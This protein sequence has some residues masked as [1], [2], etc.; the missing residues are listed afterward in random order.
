MLTKFYL[1]CVL[2]IFTKFSDVQS[3]ECS[4]QLSTLG[5]Y[6]CSINEQIILSEENLLPV[7]GDHLPG[8]DN[9][10]VTILWSVGSDIQVFPSIVIDEFIN[11]ESVILSSGTRNFKSHI[12]NC[13]NLGILLL[14][15]NRITAISGGIFRNCR[16][17]E[18]LGMINGLINS[19]DE[20]AFEGLTGLK[21][22]TL[23][24]NQIKSLAP[25]TFA[26]LH[27]LTQ[28]SIDN[29]QLE[30]ITSGIFDSL[31]LLETL[32]L[33]QNNITSWDPSILENNLKLRT[34]FLSGNL[35]QIIDGNTFA[36]LQNLRLLSVGSL[37]E[38]IPTFLNLGQL[39]EL[40]LN[41]NRIKEVSA[42]SFKSLV[43]LKVLRLSFNEIELVN[44]TM[45]PEKILSQL[46]NLT[47]MFNRLTTLQ[48]NA[49]SMLE[50]MNMLQ[51]AFNQIE[52]LNE[53]TIRPITQ[54]RYLDIRSNRVRK[55]EQK[56]F[57]GVSIL[58][59]RA[60]NNICFNANFTIN[61][62]LNN[63]DFETRI[64]PLMENCFNF[65]TTTKDNLLAVIISFFIASI[66]SFR[67]K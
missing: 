18:T 3:V 63:Y 48:D 29:N 36:N 4:F 61:N 66:M 60:N 58:E 56:L 31:T 50:N 28:L 55:I 27:L 16:R 12:S 1:I 11:L 57:D 5:V 8:Y 34:L 26:N 45:R 20:N 37:I 13:N 21:Q 53:N 67:L 33:R 19:I 43:S 22:L 9:S 2:I 6:S 54:L 25:R 30:G 35:I 64:L 7:T 23:S 42:D 51:L 15:S 44:F 17:L 62:T 38:E 40:N 52:R 49:F 59:F 14:L 46:E 39:E 10:N 65:G 41:S 32:D 47:L 24:I